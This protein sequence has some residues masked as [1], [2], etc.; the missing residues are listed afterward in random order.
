MLRASC[1]SS[2]IPSL[3]NE[4]IMD[5][6]ASESSSSKSINSKVEQLM[7]TLQGL[8]KH[9]IKKQQ[10]SINSL[11]TWLEHDDVAGEKFDLNNSTAV[12][13]SIS[14]CEFLSQENGTYIVL[15]YVVET[16][17]NWVVSKMHNFKSFDADMRLLLKCS[18]VL[19]EFLMVA[20]NKDFLKGAFSMSPFYTQ[21]IDVFE[22]KFFEVV[23][24]DLSSPKTNS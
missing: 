9:V 19:G 4:L 10:V 17:C 8:M 13:L 20:E 21:L 24:F 3:E 11:E 14:V 23:S 7:K 6:A 1:P 16:L 12:C 5:T 18:K 2:Y 22:K 15:E